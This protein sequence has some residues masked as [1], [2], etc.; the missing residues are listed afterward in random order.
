MEAECQG[1]RVEDLLSGKPVHVA[2][3]NQIPVTLPR[4]DGTV[5]RFSTLEGEEGKWK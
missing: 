2:E 4:K 5:I 1:N 3:K